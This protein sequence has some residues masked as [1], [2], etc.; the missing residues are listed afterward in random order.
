[1]LVSVHGDGEFGPDLPQQELLL[2]PY[3]SDGPGNPPVPNYHGIPS[4]NNH[5]T[6]KPG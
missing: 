6:N 5:I 4:N 1:M 3:S 2:N